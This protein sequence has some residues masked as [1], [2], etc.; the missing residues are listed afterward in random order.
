LA[1]VT[2]V[3]QTTARGGAVIG[4]SLKTIFTRIQRTD[5]LNALEDLGIKVRDVEGN[6]LPAIQ[7]LTNLSQ[8][9]DQ[10]NDSQKA[11]TGELVGGVFQI[12]I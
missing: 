2:S 3:Q 11:A 9:F 1:I 5:T 8:T 6:T 10:L 7:V 12:N 4:N